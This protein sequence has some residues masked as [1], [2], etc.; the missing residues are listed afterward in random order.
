MRWDEKRGVC[1]ILTKINQIPLF[2]SSKS[3]RDT[4]AFTE[5][6]SIPKWTSQTGDKLSHGH[7]HRHSSVSFVRHLIPYFLTGWGGW[8]TVDDK[9]FLEKD[10]NKCSLARRIICKRTLNWLSGKLLGR[11]DH[12]HQRTKHEWLWR[13]KAPAHKCLVLVFLLA[14][15]EGHESSLISPLTMNAMTFVTFH[16]PASPSAIHRFLNLQGRRCSLKFYPSPLA[17]LHR[18]RTC[19]QKQLWGADVGAKRKAN[20]IIQGE[21]APDT[22]CIYSL[23][24]RKRSPSQ[25]NKRL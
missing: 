21:D 3:S 8:M 14:V 13:W 9:D 25:R 19:I 5:E 24:I 23:V 16:Q 11:H 6:L 15:S 12:V 22:G 2:R 4:L 1:Y 7:H 20:D 10:E 18:M 17:R